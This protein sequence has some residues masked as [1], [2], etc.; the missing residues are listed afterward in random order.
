MLVTRAGHSRER[1]QAIHARQVSGF[2]PLEHD[3]KHRHQ[4]AEGAAKFLIHGTWR[5]RSLP[6]RR[7]KPKTRVREPGFPRV[8]V[9]GDPQCVEHRA[10]FQPVGARGRCGGI[11]SRPGR[12]RTAR[13]EQ[14]PDQ[15]RKLVGQ[16]AKGLPHRPHP[17]VR[18]PSRCGGHLRLRR[19][20]VRPGG[21]RTARSE[22]SSSRTRW[23]TRRA[24]EATGVSLF[25]RVHASR[26]DAAG[27]APNRSSRRTILARRTSSSGP[28]LMGTS[29]RVITPTPL[30]TRAHPSRQGKCF[31]RLNR[32]INLPLFGV[33]CP[34]RKVS[35]GRGS[36]DRCGLDEVR[37]EAVPAVRAA[38]PVVH[39]LDMA[40]PAVARPQPGPQDPEPAAPGDCDQHR[41]ETRAVSAGLRP[42][43]FL[44]WRRHFLCVR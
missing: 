14:G 43:V 37:V 12:A 34:G 30:S 28:L 24:S 22:L 38:V 3:I 16:P 35:P 36:R 33:I 8:T 4:A 39:V 44:P 20:L 31:G 18:L 9:V 6:C 5:P 11:G 32:P 19:A 40:Q 27:P 7:R 25:I 23:P 15:L 41:L 10:H 29:G 26:K 21:S 2:V 42:Q 17:P 1:V 13:P